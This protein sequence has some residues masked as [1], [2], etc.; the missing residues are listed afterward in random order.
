M[1]LILTLIILIIFSYLLQLLAKKLK[2]PNVVALILAGLIISFPAIKSYLVGDNSLFIFN[3]GDFALICLMFMAGLESSSRSLYNERKD[4]IF[5]T[6]FAALT[7]LALGFITFKLLG[8]STLV[9]FI[10]GICMSI[11]A[12]ATN[13]RVLMDLRKIKTKVGSAMMDAGIIDDVLGL[14]LFLIITYILK[15]NYLREDILIVGAIL[16][17]FAGIMAENYLGRKHHSIKLIEKPLSLLVIPFF[18][19][20]MGINFNIKS[21]LFNPAL[22]LII[23]FIAIIGKIAGTF[24]AKPFTRFSWK[25]LHLIG[26]GMNSRGAIELALALIAFRSS[27]IPTELYSS[28]VLMALI[29]TLIFPFILAKMIKTNPSLM[30]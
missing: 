18:F 12:E 1:N 23:I 29:T 26:W 8:F 28:L 5:I 2:I 25:Q 17:F 4:A 19:I 7:P 3:L 16:A 9:S 20:S 30:R 13:A 15:S 24:M 27:L 21:L 22:L 6:I 10:V 14:S 11:T